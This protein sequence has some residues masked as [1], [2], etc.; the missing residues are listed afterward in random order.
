[1]SQ[2]SDAVI[3]LARSAAVAVAPPLEARLREVYGAGWLAAVNRR[4]T[5]EGRGTGHGLHDHRFCLTLLGYDPATDG[6]APPSTR[7][8]AR[9]L[10]GLA[11]RAHHDEA[12]STDDLIG[13]RSLADRLQ[14]WARPKRR[15]DPAPARRPATK[16][17]ARPARP[18]RIAPSDRRQEPTARIVA[19]A[20]AIP[21]RPAPARS[22]PIRRRPSPPPRP[23]ERARSS[24]TG[25]G[26]CL[27]MGLVV[28]L[29]AALATWYL[30]SSR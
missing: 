21:R 6:W 30:A 8:D 3:A 2:R 1:V 24:E 26:T 29:V 19:D 22:T 16:Q 12:L 15:A 17:A 5:A 27:V 7:R 9:D 18:P 14:S 4:R 10:T 11:H 25:F 28:V 13:A 20:D 23:P